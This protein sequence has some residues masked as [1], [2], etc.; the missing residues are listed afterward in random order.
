MRMARV[1]CG[2]LAMLRHVVLTMWDI[3]IL[4]QEMRLPASRAYLRTRSTSL[5]VLT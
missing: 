2:K 4:I 1:I 5:F 3:E